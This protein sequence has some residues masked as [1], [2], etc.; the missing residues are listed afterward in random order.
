MSIASTPAAEKPKKAGFPKSIPFIVGN[1]AAERFSFYGM[2]AILTTYLASQF[3]HAD[4][5]AN[6]KTHLFIAMAYLMPL[7]GGIMADWFWGK[8]KTIFWLSLVYCVG[9]AFLAIFEVNL[10]GFL[11][12]L[13][14]IAIGSGG[15]KPCVSANVGDQFNKSNEHLISKAFDM[16]YFSINFGSFFSTLWIPVLMKNYGAAVAF[17]VPGILMAIATFIFWLGRKRY[18]RVPPSG[19]RNEEF[20]NINFY[21]L[22]NSKHST[23][24]RTINNPLV[25]MSPIITG[26]LAFAIALAI[27]PDFIDSPFVILMPVSGIFFFFLIVG[28]ASMIKRSK[29]ENF[30]DIAER[31]YT[32]KQIG[33]V[34]SVWKVLI[35]FA[36]I[37]FF[38]ALY[39]Q[40]GSEWVLQAQQ[41]K[42][43]DPGSM[44][45]FGVNWLPE[46]VQSIN[47]ILILAF[48]P[49]FSLVL[50][51]L[52]GRMGVKVT[53]LRKI[54]AGLVLTALSFVVIGY[55]Q[56][57][58]DAGHSPNV[59][60]QFLAYTIL[61]AGEVLISITGLE[62]A[63]TMAPK[64][65]KST[66]MSFWLLTVS[67]GN[68]LVTLINNSKTNGGFFA[69]FE[70][71]GYYWLFL[72]IIG[73]VFVVY[74]IVSSLMKEGD[75]ITSDDDD[76]TA[77][78][79]L[80]P[81]IVEN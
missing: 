58:L 65:M 4:A 49:L 32:K 2:K 75:R 40:N 45:C 43:L 15:I 44:K 59:I 35:V 5:P 29:K 48:I 78:P 10:N 71:A 80:N 66:I 76:T 19:F 9:H 16:F 67:L 70:G 8:Y 22:L 26:I 69:K 38:W 60:W 79:P 74:L 37:P 7:I 53:P 72:G 47:P 18:V 1:E 36:F 39:D 54:G 28:I 34:R 62:Y 3:Y 11:A 68:I 61:T 21:S 77:Y 17:G 57:Q 27:D 20:Y 13:M 30:Y 56:T 23:K 24:E 6:E 64:T 51:P 33:A 12:G 63:Y 31:K 42:N 73:G 50:Y 52:I 81:T 46:Q 25:L 55:I 41:M 14:L